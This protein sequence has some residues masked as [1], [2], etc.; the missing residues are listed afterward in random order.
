MAVH[1]N[2]TTTLR[3]LVGAKSVEVEGG[4]V[5]EVLANLEARTLSS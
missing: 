5:S 4:T 1:V 2:V 3:N